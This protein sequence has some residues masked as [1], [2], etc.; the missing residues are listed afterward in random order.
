MSNVL[1]S[2]KPILPTVSL[3]KKKKENNVFLLLIVFA[4]FNM[5]IGGKMIWN[6]RN[7]RYELGLDLVLVLYKAGGARVVVVLL[8]QRQN[9]LLIARLQFLFITVRHVNSYSCCLSEIC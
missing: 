7:R 6:R 9:C 8:L 3:T 1:P 2:V 5:S 4:A